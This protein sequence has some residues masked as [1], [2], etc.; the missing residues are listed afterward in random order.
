MKASA[1]PNVHTVMPEKTHWKAEG[2][3]EEAGRVAPWATHPSES[4]HR[5]T[6]LQSPRTVTAKQLESNF[7]DLSFLDEIPTGLELLEECDILYV[8]EVLLSPTSTTS[9]AGIK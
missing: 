2:A 1:K 6:A 3:A 4:Q 7:V 8:R 5:S 9:I